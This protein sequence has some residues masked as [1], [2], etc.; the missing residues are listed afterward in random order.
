M[1]REYL[2]FY[3]NK[4]HELCPKSVPLSASSIKRQKRKIHARETDRYLCES[5]REAPVQL[6]HRSSFARVALINI[7]SFLSPSARKVLTLVLDLEIEVDREGVSGATSAGNGRRRMA[8]NAGS[9]QSGSGGR[10]GGH[11]GG[12]RGVR[13]RTGDAVAVSDG[14]GDRRRGGDG[15]RRDGR[16]GGRRRRRRR[17]LLV[18]AAFLRLFL[19]LDLVED[20]RRCRS[21]LHFHTREPRSHLRTTP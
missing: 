1:V 14:G 15:K 4:Q 6:T 12:R 3:T 9:L 20:R 13:A 16:G 8:D 7:F 2:Q 10:D 5:A 11:R 21:A 18:A 17:G 19:N